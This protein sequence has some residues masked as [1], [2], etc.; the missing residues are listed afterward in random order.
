MENAVEKHEPSRWRRWLVV[1]TLWLASGVTFGTW[2]GW[3]DSVPQPPYGLE[4]RQ[5][6]RLGAMFNGDSADPNVVCL[7]PPGQPPRCFSGGLSDD[8]AQARAAAELAE[9]RSV[10]R[11]FWGVFTLVPPAFMGIILLMIAQ[12]GGVPAGLKRRDPPAE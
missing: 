3:H 11:A 6:P 9:E 10:V 8:Q 4:R 12:S 7:R 1:G 5:D 2:M